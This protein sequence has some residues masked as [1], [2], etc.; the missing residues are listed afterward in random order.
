MDDLMISLGSF[1]LGGMI[2][3]ILGLFTGIFDAILALL[4]GFIP[5]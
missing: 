4:T 1:D 2:A 5:M 3:A